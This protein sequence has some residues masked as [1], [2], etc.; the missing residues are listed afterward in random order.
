MNKAIK[1]IL[2]L[3]LALV[4]ALGALPS[5]APTM[6]LTTYA[7]QP[8]Y[9]KDMA[10]GTWTGA[11]RR[12]IAF[13]EHNGSPILWRVLEVY[14]SDGTADN[15]NG[16]KTALLLA[17]DCVD[18]LLFGSSGDGNWIN[19]EIKT[20]LN[21]NFFDTA[22]DE[23]EQSAIVTSTYKLGGNYFYSGY[24]YDTDDDSQVF[25][26][27]VDEATD[28]EYF[29]DGANS[30]R[31]VDRDA[32]AEWWL[33]SP[34]YNDNY[35][36]VVQSGG[37]VYA[38]GAPWFSDNGIRP[39]L[40]VNLA[41]DIFTSS[42]ILYSPEITVRDGQGNR[43][44]GVHISL[45]GASAPDASFFT[46]DGGSGHFSERFPAGEYALTVTKAGYPT[47]TGTI[48][49]WE[50]SIKHAVTLS[51]AGVP[52]TVRFGR[53]SGNAVNWRVLNIAGGKALLLCEDGLKADNWAA[54][55]SWINNS[56]TGGFLENF[57][58]GELDAMEDHSG[59]TGNPFLL[60]SQEATDYLP[61]NAL[62]IFSHAIN[63]ERYWWLRDN[64]GSHPYTVNFTGEIAIRNATQSYDARPAVWLDL[65]KLCQVIDSGITTFVPAFAATVN[66]EDGGNT[67]VAGVSLTLA[68]TSGSD[69]IRGGDGSDI[70]SGVTAGS[71]EA[72]FALPEGTYD[73]SVSG[74]SGLTGSGVL[75]VSS[76]GANAVT[77]T[78]SP[79]AAPTQSP[80]DL[81]RTMGKDGSASFDADDIATDTDV[82]DTLTITAIHTHPDSAVAT[83]SLDNGTVTVSAVDYGSAS[84][85]VTVTDGGSDV[86]IPV[87]IKVTD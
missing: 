61:T 28:S 55:D 19:S 4:L 20:W 40:K 84:V 63:S 16:N 53:Y 29:E 49:V 12:T 56:S 41:S 60:S 27:S 36:A 67:P 24:G 74:V 42:E 35:V 22:F 87:P 39:A 43:I 33:R 30:G 70:L 73:I 45:S 10:V 8:D 21:G 26:L 47:Y 85:A 77:I 52:A 46:D 79:N 83:A 13:G 7:A 15:N 37:A 86:T 59:S 65:S 71:G 51:E 57:S 34:G 9:A 58:Q 66:V 44:A 82:G 17:E 72:D 76:G 81:T 3:A 14:T 78:L 64:D 75:T 69:A 68:P 25:L 5:S 50:N 2:T 18:T 32:G 48:T 1:R 11:G 6:T 54:V 38:D 31:N 62:R 80:G 23:D